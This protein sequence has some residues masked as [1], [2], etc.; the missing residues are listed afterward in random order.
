MQ[1]PVK[2]GVSTWLWTSPFRPE[3]AAG[4]FEKIA[5][6]GYEVVEIAVED[7]LLIDTQQIS[8]ELEKNGLQA[9]V[10]GAFGP[11]RD[12]TSDDE[13]LQKNGLQYIEDCLDISTELG[14]RFFAGPMY[15]AVGKERM[16]ADEQ[17]QIEGNR[18]M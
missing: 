11:T 18:E 1:L 8:K 7:P 2:L 15:S 13:S 16:V 3:D 4:L 6:L 17:S 5:S 9:L 14:A 10:C 12:L